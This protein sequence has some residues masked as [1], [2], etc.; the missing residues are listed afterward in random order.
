MKELCWLLKD[1]ARGLGSE[2]GMLQLLRGDSGVFFPALEDL[3]HGPELAVVFLGLGFARRW[4]RGKD[5]RGWGARGQRPARGSSP[6]FTFFFAPNFT[7]LSSGSE[8]GTWDS[9]CRSAEAGMWFWG[10]VARPKGTAGTGRG[11]WPPPDPMAPAPM[12]AHPLPGPGW[13]QGRFGKRWPRCHSGAPRVSPV[14]FHPKMSPQSPGGEG[15]HHPRGPCPW[16]PHPWGPH[17]GVPILV[18]SSTVEKV[19]PQTPLSVFCPFNPSPKQDEAS[20][21]VC[22]LPI[23]GTPGSLVQGTPETPP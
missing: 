5:A 20:A 2:L 23:L 11:W 12:G 18:S 22:P 7:F 8:R 4:G 16:G 21:P 6:N 17:P 14:M 15:T 1:K 3:G 19:F 13:H 9:R 10:P